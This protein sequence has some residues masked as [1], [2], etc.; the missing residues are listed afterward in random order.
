LE[1]QNKKLVILKKKQIVLKKKQKLT[2]LRKY[3]QNK[4]FKEG[5]NILVTSIAI[6]NPSKL[7]ACFIATQI[8]TLK[9]HNFF[10]RFIKNTLTLLN[11]KVFFSTIRGIKINIKGRFNGNSRA[12]NRS[13]WVSNLPP[14]LAQK[15]NIDYFKKI[16]YTI[17]G[18]FGIK[19]WVYQ[20]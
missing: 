20:Y 19:L 9:F 15:S 3:N 11:N 1:K 13:I 12:E 16:S 4:F 7:L 10:I 14:L 8:K 6:K 18:T 5:I 2:I 17:N